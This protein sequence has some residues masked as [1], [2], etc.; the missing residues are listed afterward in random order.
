MIIGFLKINTIKYL[1]DT[2][3]IMEKISSV[4][5]KKNFSKNAWIY[6]VR[7]KAKD[8]INYGYVIV[9]D[10]IA[11]LIDPSWDFEQYK[12]ILQNNC[13]T[14]IHIFITHSHYDHINLVHSFEKKFICDI[15][16][17]KIEYNYYNLH[18]DK[19]NLFD[20]ASPIKIQDFSV[21]PIFTPGHTLGSTCFLIDNS[22]FSGD[23]LFNEG[24][25]TYDNYIGSALELFNSIQC[26]KRI[27]P[28]D[29]IVYP[30]HCY[31]VPIGQSLANIFSVNMCLGIDNFRDF[32][33]HQKKVVNKNKC[34]NG[35]KFI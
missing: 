28:L 3:F 7:S 20:N 17:N 8:F 34:N 10:L 31:R 29:T 11:I 12:V 15:Y 35:S 24:C 1:F 4:I 14:Q 26:I 9:R 5:I 27:L 6:I 13:I 25:G 16:I 30:A 33:E 19:V 32:Y 21:K 2:F 18:F 22:F 23:T